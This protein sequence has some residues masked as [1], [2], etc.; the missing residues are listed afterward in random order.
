[1]HDYVPYR[2]NGP[3]RW[4]LSSRENSLSEIVLGKISLEMSSCHLSAGGDCTEIRR[5][6]P[7][8]ALALPEGHTTV[9]PSG[10]ARS[11]SQLKIISHSQI[12]HN[13]LDLRSS[14]HRPG[15]WII[16]CDY[17]GLSLIKLI[18]LL[19]RL[20]IIQLKWHEINLSI[21]H[22]GP[23][24]SWLSIHHE[25]KIQ[26]LWTEVR[27]TL[28]LPEPL[29]RCDGLARWNQRSWGT[30]PCPWW[31]YSHHTWGKVLCVRDF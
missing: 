11:A 22:Q 21:D 17:T 31:R 14:D 5:K 10:R 9:S 13:W 15:K 7:G 19:S 2:D 8:S 6:S 24:F 16:F 30:H 26:P 23:M 28:K 29:T 4:S 25:A 3:Y 1:M 12:S 27:L 18:E 20:V